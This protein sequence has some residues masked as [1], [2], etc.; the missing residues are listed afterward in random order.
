MFIYDSNFFFNNIIKLDYIGF[1]NQYK[2][3]LSSLNF[4]ENFSFLLYFIISIK[5]NLITYEQISCIYLV[6]FENNNYNF[7]YYW[8]LL[9]Q[10]Y[11]DFLNVFKFMH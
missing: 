11:I 5:M 4:V 8:F 1:V 6:Y 10:T 7:Y 2:I 3:L 9:F